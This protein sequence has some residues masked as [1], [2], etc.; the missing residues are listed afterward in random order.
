MSSLASTLLWST[1]IF[2][3]CAVT[4]VT[5]VSLAMVPSPLGLF[6]GRYP[7]WLERHT[8]FV[9]APWSGAQLAPVQLIF[10]LATVFASATLRSGLLF[11]LAVAMAT[12]PAWSLQRLHRRRVARLEEQLDS[13]LLMLSNAL[14]ASPS[15]GEAIASTANLVSAPLREELDLLIKEI[16]LG[17]S[18]DEALQN[19]TRRVQSASVS[20]ALATLVLGR[21]TGGS[22]R[23]ILE[24]TA[25]I[26]R[27]S[28][29]LEGV[30]RAKTAEGR[31]QII[32]L[33]AMPFVICSVIVWMDP[34]W[35]E[36]MRYHS[37]GQ[38]I[39]LICAVTW[40]LALLWARRIVDVET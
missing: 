38:L 22:L 7:E 29:R 21:K 39:L 31:G 28:A 24:D 15:I 32:A 37:A 11:L 6:L 33:A 2:T 20:D 10:V 40:T 19:T 17:T 23:K 12:V 26:L 36:P 25:C 14:S 8:H 1:G 5:Y 13:W 4:T 9:R 27:E 30:L 16:R 35:F 34:S 18:L 3:V